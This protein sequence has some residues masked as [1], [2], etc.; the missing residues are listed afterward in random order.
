M[1]RSRRCAVLA[2]SCPCGPDALPGGRSSLQWIMARRM[3][4]ASAILA[5]AM[6]LLVSVRYTVD[7]NNMR[8]ET[9]QHEVGVIID[10]LQKGNDPRTRLHYSQYPAN[11][12]FRV[13]DRRSANARRLVMEVNPELLLPATSGLGLADTRPEPY[14]SE[15]GGRFGGDES[16]TD[17]DQWIWTDHVDVNPKS[18]WVQ[19][20]MIGDPAR[21]WLAVIWE[22]M[23]DHVLYPM[24]MIVPPLT[25]GMVFAART[26]LRPL[27]L[28][29]ED[30]GRVGTDVRLGRSPLPLRRVPLTVE[31]DTF[32]NAIN[33]MIE[34]VDRAMRLQKQFTADAAHQLRTPLSIL[35]LRTS[36]LPPSPE[37]AKLRQELQD[38][39][40]VIGSLLQ[41]AQTEEAVDIERSL[42]D[43]V[44][45][46]RGVCETMTPAVMAQGHTLE[47]S[48][49]E[50]AFV[51]GHAGLIETA[52]RN[53][54]DNAIRYTPDGGAV[55]VSV[56]YGGT[57]TIEDNGPGFTTEQKGM[58]FERFWRAG[59]RSSAGS[60]IGL[61]LVRRITKLHGG[62]S[63]VED[64]A[65]GGTRIVLQFAEKAGDSAEPELYASARN[66]IE[67]VRASETQVGL[68]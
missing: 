3:L 5:A 14:L 56:Y 61:T 50:R 9:V 27:A 38:L 44:A 34:S 46:A 24:S 60:G 64:R 35:A 22:K 45:V 59:R 62:C 36:T 25:L 29:V 42:V 39:S 15:G 11:Y 7:T 58:A 17:V 53:V 57:V 41:L 48:A 10:M 33:A 16:Q 28:L 65:G 8:K 47:F 1:W 4:A 2:T 31:F 52:I 63:V 19:A 18:Y 26:A 51:S 20:T 6:M 30:A 40:A 13:Y 55:L 23:L 66:G 49:A 68:S 21:L 32:I 67:E 54:L 37:V 43:L 12:A